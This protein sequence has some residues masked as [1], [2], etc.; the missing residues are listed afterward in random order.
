MSAREI[1]IMSEIETVW[2]NTSFSVKR[3]ADVVCQVARSIR[4]TQARGS[5]Q[6]RASKYVKVDDFFFVEF[7]IFK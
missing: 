1:Q 7:K 4:G 2:A 6:P 5:K 3:L